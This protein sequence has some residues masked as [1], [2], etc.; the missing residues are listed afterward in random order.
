MAEKYIFHTHIK[1]QCMSPTLL[2]GDVIFVDR[3]R[4]KIH[5]AQIYAIYMDDVIAIRRLMLLSDWLVRI[6]CDNAYYPPREIS[7]R[8]V[9]MVGQVIG[10]CRTII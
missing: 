5:N 4:K 6:V 2:E 8:D 10:L 3:Q 7:L 9:N 1:D